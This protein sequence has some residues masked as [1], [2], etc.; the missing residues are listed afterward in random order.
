MVA[1]SGMI[2]YH[3]I[4]RMAS[5]SSFSTNPVTL[6]RAFL[7]SLALGLG[8]VLAQ[9]AGGGST[10]PSAEPLDFA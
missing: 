4:G 3:C 7:F 6:M 5:L 10:S 8:M 1:E 2:R 9:G